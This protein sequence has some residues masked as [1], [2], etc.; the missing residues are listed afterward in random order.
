MRTSSSTSL[1]C[2]FV[3]LRRSMRRAPPFTGRASIGCVRSSPRSSARVSAKITFRTVQKCA[4]A[5]AVT[6]AA[7]TVATSLAASSPAFFRVRPQYLRDRRQCE[8]H[9]ARAC[10]AIAVL[11]LNSKNNRVVNVVARPTLRSVRGCWRRDL[12]G[13]RAIGEP[14]GART[15]MRDFVPE[16][17]L[18]RLDS[19]QQPSG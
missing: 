13:D 18:L 9:F 4:R 2:R 3:Q 15:K 16:I 1:S 6:T 10:F 8:I 11:S 17:W 7:P 5:T 19:N 14:Q 12:H